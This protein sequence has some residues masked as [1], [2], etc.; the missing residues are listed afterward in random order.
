MGTEY[1]QEVPRKLVKSK[2]FE[3]VAIGPHH[4]LAVTN[5]GDLYGWG[6][7][8]AGKDSQSNEPA[9]IVV[10]DV[11][12]KHVACGYQ[13]NAAVSVDGQVY[14]WGHGGSWF[15]GGG[16]LGAAAIVAVSGVMK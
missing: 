6:K 8:F 13:H 9:P 14:T 5:T 2:R 10:A 1:I 16:Q 7:G 12:F 4:T 15:S 11:K 3:K